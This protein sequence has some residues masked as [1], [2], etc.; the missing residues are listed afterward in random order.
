MPLKKVL[1]KALLRHEELHTVLCE[2]ERA[3]NSRP[4]THVGSLLDDPALTPAQLMGQDVWLAQPATAP[5]TGEGMQRCARYLTT[6]CQHLQQR[7]M[8][9]YLVTLQSYHAGQSMPVREDVVL[10][11]DDSK[12]RLLWRMACVAQLY[13]GRDGKSRIALVSLSGGGTL[14]RPVRRLLPLEVSR[15]IKECS[16]CS[17]YPT[18]VAMDRSLALANG[19]S[20]VVV[21][22]ERVAV[23]PATDN[24]APTPDK[25]CGQ[26]MLTR[27]VQP[28][29]RLNL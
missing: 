23:K 21:P 3:M 9:E 11:A 24:D 22:A 14:L 13:P 27:R 29:Q 16:A 15:D 20:K 12:R 25:S 6:V 26:L 19:C 5:L 10:L 4:L 7:W 1:G 8:T 28:P 18:V 2:V 17:A